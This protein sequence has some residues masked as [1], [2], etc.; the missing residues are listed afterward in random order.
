MEVESMFPMITTPE[1]FVK[2]KE[3]LTEVYGGLKDRGIE[4]NESPSE[5]NDR[6]TFC[7]IR[8]DGLQKIELFQY[9]TMI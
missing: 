5:N 9:R 4:F 7:S 3:V 8:A 1:E 2:T 6:S